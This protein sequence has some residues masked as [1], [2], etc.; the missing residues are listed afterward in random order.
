[1]EKEIF[2]KEAKKIGY[3]PIF[4]NEKLMDCVDTEGSLVHVIVDFDMF[5]KRK[6]TFSVSVSGAKIVAE[7]I[8]DYMKDLERAQ[9]FIALAK[10]YLGQA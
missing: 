4:M 9:D 2:E 1:M 7:Q 8:G 10:A 3:K 6:T 5:G